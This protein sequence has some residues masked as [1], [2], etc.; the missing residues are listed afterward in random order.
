MESCNLGLISLYQADLCNY[1]IEY[2]E[3]ISKDFEGDV[4]WCIDV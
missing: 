3:D 4:D 2:F 1:N